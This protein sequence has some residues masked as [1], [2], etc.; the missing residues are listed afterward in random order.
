[1]YGK[2]H[3]SDGKLLGDH[4]N[5]ATVPEAG[6][7]A[8]EKLQVSP[9]FTLLIQASYPEAFFMATIHTSKRDGR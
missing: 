5:T 8:P 6:Q 4:D 7:S 3:E 1:M 2:I 9:G